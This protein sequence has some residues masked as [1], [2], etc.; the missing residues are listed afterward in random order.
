M[1]VFV[2]EKKYGASGEY[3]FASGVNTSAEGVGSAVFGIGTKAPY[4]GSFVAGTF[5][6]GD[7]SKNVYE[8]GIGT[9]EDDRKNAFEIKDDGTLTAPES[10]IDLINAR[11]PK[12]LVTKEYVENISSSGSGELV[13]V[14]NKGWALREIAED[15]YSEYGEIGECAVNFSIAGEEGPYFGSYGATGNYAFA[16]GMNAVAS[17]DYSHTE[18]RINVASAHAAHAEGWSTEATGGQSH[19]EGHLTKATSINSHAEG[20]ETESSG[21]AS[22]SEGWGTIAQNDVSHAAG[23][24]N[25]GTSPDTIHETGIGEY[26]DRKN[27]FEIYIDGTLT[28]PESTIDLINA[29]GPKTL[30][31]KEYVENISSSGSNNVSVL[32]DLQ[33]VSA[34]RVSDNFVLTYQ[35]GN[36]MPESINY[37]LTDA[38]LSDLKDVDSRS[39]LDPID[40]SILYAS[41]GSWQGKE[42]NMVSKQYI[43][44]SDLKDVDE[45]TTSSPNEG[46]ML[47]YRNGR[48]VSE[49]NSSQTGV[50]VMDSL[51]PASSQYFKKMVF[52]LADNSMYA[53]VA[54]TT[55]PT[56]DRDYFWLFISSIE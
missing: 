3:S 21:F 24:Y 27:A 36:W 16:E 51:P 13:K 6:K 35:S 50:D 47:V 31:T 23:K 19:A 54:N 56:S 10:T 12:T 43:S 33:D 22:H 4:S 26:N 7:S 34:D 11:G 2:S 38:Y 39:V 32:N 15:P 55:T 5:N 49:Q 8:F 9:G 48:W 41:N 37:L 14:N 25:I 53:C 18:G 30:V 17:G 1:A 52:S 46:D 28:A 29:R 45:N 40:G 44:I 42:I 20:M